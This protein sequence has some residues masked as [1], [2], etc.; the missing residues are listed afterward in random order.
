LR[1]Y[2]VWEIAKM[3]L[4]FQGFPYAGLTRGT[5]CA[6]GTTYDK[7]GPSEGCIKVCEGYGSE[8]CG[9]DAAAN[10]YKISKLYTMR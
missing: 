3:L 7:Y 5:D 8:M 9:G 1:C 6:C 10:V 2:Y 4:Q